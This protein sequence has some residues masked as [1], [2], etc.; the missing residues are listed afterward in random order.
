MTNIKS[1]ITL[2][3]QTINV[4]VNLQSQIG[5]SLQIVNHGDLQHNIEISRTYFSTLYSFLEGVEEL[6]DN[7]DCVHFMQKFNISWVLNSSN[8]PIRTIEPKQHSISK[9]DFM[10]GQSIVSS[11]NPNRYIELLDFDYRRDVFITS[12]TISFDKYINA[13]G[14]KNVNTLYNMYNQLIIYSF[15]SMDGIHKF[16]DHKN[17]LEI[18]SI[19]VLFQSISCII[20]YLKK[21]C[22]KLIQY[23]ELYLFSNK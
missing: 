5:N 6:K 16:F 18:D 10:I 19:T 23:Y 12:Q 20:D 14:T 1:I 22:N 2:Y 11:N 13:D 9:K 21:Y 8:I 17:S 4:L 7:P 15:I 3:E